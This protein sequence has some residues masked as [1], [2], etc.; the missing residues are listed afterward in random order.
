MAAVEI[1]ISNDAVIEEDEEFSISLTLLPTNN[2]RVTLGVH[3]TTTAVIIDTSM[4][5]VN[6]IRGFGGNL[7]WW[8]GECCK[9]YQ[10]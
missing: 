4:L 10:K 2:T 8:F 7:I 1:P 6:H 9:N 3:S 5:A